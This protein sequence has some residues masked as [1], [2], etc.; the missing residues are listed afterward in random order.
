MNTVR[1]FIAIDLS[2][3]I[4]QSL[5]KTAHALQARLPPNAVRWVAVNN[6]HLTLKFLGELNSHQIEA[7][8]AI[9]REAAQRQSQFD[10]QVGELGVFPSLSRPRV[11]WVGVKAPACL[12]DLQAEIDSRIAS[13]RTLSTGNSRDERDFAPHL[14]LGRVTREASP[15][16]VRKISE[17]IKGFPV[18]SLGI[19]PALAL[20]LYRSDLRPSGPIYTRLYS[21]A[22]QPLAELYR[23]HE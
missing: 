16:A 7:V 10:L 1:A 2:A 20:N 5:E 11:I 14:T 4:L 3:A 23:N 13:S 6:L 19:S 12:A 9:L 18:G 15:E 8:Q 22:L 17:T 21:A